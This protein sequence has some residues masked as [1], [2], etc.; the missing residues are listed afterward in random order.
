MAENNTFRPPLATANQ[1]STTQY[2]DLINNFT[3]YVKAINALKQQYPNTRITYKTNLSESNIDKEQQTSPEDRANMLNM[4]MGLYDAAKPQ[5]PEPVN[6][7]VEKAQKVGAIA[8]A[9]G[10]SLANFVSSI[11]PRTTA[12]FTS[13]PYVSSYLTA[14]QKNDMLDAMAKQQYNQQLVQHEKGKIPLLLSTFRSSTGT[15]NKSG[16][17]LTVSTQDQKTGGSSGRQQTKKATVLFDVA[18]YTVPKE[19]IQ[20]LFGLM[21]RDDQIKEIISDVERD[22]GIESYITGNTPDYYKY[23]TVIQETLNRLKNTSGGAAKYEAIKNRAAQIYDYN[24][25]YYIGMRNYNESNNSNST[26]RR[27]LNKPTVKLE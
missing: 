21:K 18:G 6:R 9:L 23:N 12:G 3:T 26:G 27:V 4:L 24:K 15:G 10:S 2:D 22:L 1:N 5:Q 19:N 13:R 17:S 16:T 20:E 7:D 25:D 14:K 8:S 11:L